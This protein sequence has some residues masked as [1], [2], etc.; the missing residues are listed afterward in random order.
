MFSSVMCGHRSGYRSANSSGD[1]MNSR[2]EGPYDLPHR[3][4]LVDPGDLRTGHEAALRPFGDQADTVGL[5]QA[6]DQAGR[7][8]VDETVGVLEDVD[9]VL[10]GTGVREG[11]GGELDDVGLPA[12]GRV[13]G[14]L[15][16]AG[17]A[18]G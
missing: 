6:H 8:E 14:G 15:F 18:L 1:S 16:T 11:G 17:R 10:D 2:R 13:L 12:P 4:L 7:A 9:D 3:V 5:D